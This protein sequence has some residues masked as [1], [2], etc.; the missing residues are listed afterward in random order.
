MFVPGKI[1]TVRCTK[2]IA[3][4]HTIMRRSYLSQAWKLLKQ[5]WTLTVRVRRPEQALRARRGLKTKA[6]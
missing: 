2:R 6:D 5:L 1:V 3:E 4:S